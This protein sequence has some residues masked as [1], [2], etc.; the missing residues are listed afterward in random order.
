MS[1]AAPDGPMAQVLL[2]N[3]SIPASPTDLSVHPS[4]VAQT[5]RPISP[6]HSAQL[7]PTSN[8]EQQH[9]HAHFDDQAESRSIHSVHPDLPVFDIEHTPV[10]NDPREWS[11]RK[12]HVILVMMSVAC[13]SRLY[14]EGEQVEEA[15]ADV[16]DR[17]DVSAEHL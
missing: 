16:S 2:P 9:P 4:N 11:V 7:P 10:D 6:A 1:T 8:R 14:V 5:R 3:H 12:K 13:V 15:G 17:T